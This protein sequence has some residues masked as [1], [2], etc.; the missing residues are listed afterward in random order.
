MYFIWTLDKVIQEAHRIQS[1]NID[2]S[3]SFLP[4]ETKTKEDVLINTKTYIE[5]LDRINSE[6]LHGDATLKLHQFGV[7]KFPEL[8]KENVEKVV[9]HA[10]KL[11]IFIWVDMER[12]D[13]VD[14]TIELFNTLRKNYKNVGICLQTCLKRT[15]GDMHELLKT[16]TPMRLVKG[17]FYIPYDIH[18]WSKVTE[19]FSKLM[20]YMLENSDRPCIA[21][22]DVG[23]IKEAKEIIK[24]KNIKNAEFQF[25]YGVKNN[26][27]EKLSSEGY[28][29]AIYIPYGNLFSYIWHGVHTFDINRNIQRVLRFKDIK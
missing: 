11:G 16:R 3:I 22:H 24:E 26:V 29:T 12:P 13:T 9:A 17:G 23:L 20:A 8:M 2:I 5:I 28:R 21:T 19:N 18:D 14:I 4:V 10:N 6:K 1:K 7:Y 25:F 27:A 15:E